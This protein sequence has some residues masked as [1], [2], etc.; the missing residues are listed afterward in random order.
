MKTYLVCRNSF[1]FNTSAVTLNLISGRFAPQAEIFHEM[2]LLCAFTPPL[3]GGCSHYV[4]DTLVL[5]VFA[6]SNEYS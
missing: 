2:L 6:P 4:F 3:G 5:T 1:V